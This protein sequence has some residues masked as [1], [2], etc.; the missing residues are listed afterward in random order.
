MNNVHVRIFFRPMFGIFLGNKKVIEFR[1][2]INIQETLFALCTLGNTYKPLLLF[3][4]ERIRNIFKEAL[5]YA[6]IPYGTTTTQIDSCCGVADFPTITP[7][8][9][10]TPLCIPSFHFWISAA[11]I[12]NPLIVFVPSIF[13]NDLS[14]HS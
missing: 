11:L 8:S 9:S 12:Q 1:H 14:A 5:M 2:L 6:P 4:R 7:F 13:L 10:F 3:I